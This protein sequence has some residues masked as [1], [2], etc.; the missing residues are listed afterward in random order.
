MTVAQIERVPKRRKQ[1]VVI[2]TEALDVVAGAGVS[3]ENDYAAVLL[4]VG[5]SGGGDHERVD[6]FLTHVG[7]RV[8]V[9]AVR[10]A[11]R[12]HDFVPR[13]GLVLRGN[14]GNSRRRSRLG[15]HPEKGE[16]CEYVLFC[17]SSSLFHDFRSPSK[18][19]S[20]VMHAPS[21]VYCS[22]Y[23]DDKEQQLKGIMTVI[24][25]CDCLD[26]NDNN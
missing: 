11:W 2:T 5:A 24:L 14:I 3:N 25:F 19:Q 8:D 18:N 22:N 17:E 20:C 1:E 9:V 15:V 26:V 4:C 16:L 13:G 7:A 12:H 10:T 23:L 6:S 21:F